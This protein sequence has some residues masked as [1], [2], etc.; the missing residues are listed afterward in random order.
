MPTATTDPIPSAETWN[1]ACDDRRAGIAS[2]ACSFARTATST[3]TARSGARI[4]VPP[5]RE[6][7]SASASPSAALKASVFSSSCAPTN[8]ALHSGES[9]QELPT[10]RKRMGAAVS[11]QSRLGPRSSA[12]RSAS[13]NGRMASAQHVAVERDF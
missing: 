6:T 3:A 13:S 9:P 10:E 12:M 4:A 2:V 5:S 7:I 11:S 1:E 8:G